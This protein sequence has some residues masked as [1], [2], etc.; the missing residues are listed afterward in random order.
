MHFLAISDMKKFSISK[1]FFHMIYHLPRLY[2]ST[3]ENIFTPQTYGAKEH[4]V[5]GVKNPIFSLKTKCIYCDR[6]FGPRTKLI[7]VGSTYI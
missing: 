1:I 7:I 5:Y 4:F 6:G 3:V 2:W